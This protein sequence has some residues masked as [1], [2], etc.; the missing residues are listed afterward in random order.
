VVM[1]VAPLLHETLTIFKASFLGALRNGPLN[2]GA[3]ARAEVLTPDI[4]SPN[5]LRQKCSQA[6]GS[7]K[8][9]ALLRSKVNCDGRLGP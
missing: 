4:S 6:E 8:I 9:A 2:D 3:F 7:L 5:T 1:H